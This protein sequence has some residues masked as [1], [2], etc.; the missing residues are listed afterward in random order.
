MKAHLLKNLK[1]F[2]GL[3]VLL[4]FATTVF[5]HNPRTM[6]ILNGSAETLSKMDLT[7]GAITHN[8][9]KTG[10]LPNQILTHHNLVY[11]VNS[12]TD[13]IQVVDPQQNHQIIRTIALAEGNNPYSMAF[14]GENKAYVTNWIANSVSVIDLEAGT[15]LKEIPV[16]KAPQGILVLGNQLLVANT[17]YAGW[18]EPYEQAAISIIDLS[19]EVVTHT[20]EVPTNAQD[21]AVDAD[22]RIHVVCTGNY[23]DIPGK[24]AIIDLETGAEKNTP[25]VVD[26]ILI[27]GTPADLAITSVGK[28]YCVDW[29]NGTNGFLY[30]YDACNH[31]V[32]HGVENPL[33]IGPNVSRLLYDV[34]LNVLWIPYMKEWGGDGFVQK[35]DVA[36]DSV[37]WISSVVGNGTQEVVILEASSGV[38]IEPKPVTSI[39]PADFKLFQNFPNPFNAETTIEFVVKKKMPVELRLFNLQGQFI[40]TLAK[41]IFVPGRYSL[42]WDGTDERQQAVSSGTYIIQMQSGDYQTARQLILLK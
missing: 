31:S 22:G 17:G 1:L 16:G 42:K 23:A 28:G 6:Y 30:E 40:R 24:I 36:T 12:G 9:V 41:E 10:Q 14:G 7:T 20:L 15:V 27:G 2:I 18:G 8:I 35:F 33:L 37:V 38:G 26:T 13:D 39:V 11:V 34:S 4:T 3:L 25:A 21:L 29:G 32:I 19:A 5:A